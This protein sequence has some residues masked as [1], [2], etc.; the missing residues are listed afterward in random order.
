M[1]NKVRI[2]VLT[3][4][5]DLRSGSTAG[6]SFGI[7]K[8]YWRSAF[9]R[10]VPDKPDVIV[11]PEACDRFLDMNEKEIKDY[12][13]FRENESPGFFN[14]LA[15]EY[16]SAVIYNTRHENKN[17]TFACNRNGDFAGKYIKAFPMTTEMEQGIAPGRGAEILRLGSIEK[18]GFITCFDLNFIELRDEYVELKPDVLFFCSMY[19]G[20]LAQ[21]M[22]AYTTR[23]FLVSSICGRKS[24]IMAPNGR[25]LAETTN[26]TDHCT[27]DINLDCR[28]VHLGYNVEKL[29]AVKDKYKDKVSIDDVG[30]LGPVL[31]G[32]ETEVSA[33]EILKEFEIRDLDEYLDFS[34][35]EIKRAVENG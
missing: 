16:D 33:E 2:S 6:E 7:M 21:K 34:R 12:A 24:G 23:S 14:S 31:L 3:G 26:Y 25:I 22:W 1:A 19:H 11:L 15:R 5:R 27:A 28:L 32:S 8:D 4:S 18:A 10:V 29:K 9:E 30:Y 13:Y 17:T 35:S 20:G